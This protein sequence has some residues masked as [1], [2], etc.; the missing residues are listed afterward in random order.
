MSNLFQE[1][2]KGLNL[3]QKEAVDTIEGPVMVIAGPGTG[4]TQILTLRIARIL[5]ETD[6]SGDGILCL[7]FT[8][9]GVKA[10]RERLHKYIGED[11]RS[12]GIQ[13][14]HSF[15]N[16]LV[17]KYYELLEFEMP[18]KL[19][20]EEDAVLVVD[21]L[22]HARD[23]KHLHSRGNPALYF[24]DLKNLVSLLKRER[25]SHFDFMVEI[26]RDI[27]RLKNDPD[28][29]STRG[30]SKGNLKKEIQKKI[31]S[32]SR[33][34]EV[35]IF[36]ELYESYK[37]EN[38]LV[39]YDDVLE[40]AVKLV[41]ENDGVCADL[42]EAYLYV[43]VDEHQDS[44][45][46]QNAFLQAVWKST[47]KPN[48]FVVGDDRQ[49][50]Y[51][52]GGAS[53]SYFEEFKTAFGKA[54]LITLT[55]NYRSTAPILSLA[56][57]LLKS[58]LTHEKLNSNRE[59]TH[60]VSLFEYVYP[61]D[62]IIGAGLY[63]KQQI[64]NGIAP[65][66]CALLVPKNRH[67]LSALS[68]LQNLGIPVRS[69]H[70]VSFF[71]AHETQSFRNVL[72]V[73]VNPF[74]T[75]ALSQTILDRTSNIPIL[76][77]HTFLHE[78]D[79]RK[80]SVDTLV[81]HGKS[82]S[83]FDDA[84][85][86]SKWGKTL[87]LWITYSHTHSLI[88]II[89]KIGNELLVEKAVG[90]EELVLRVEIVR[91]SIHLATE[92]SEK[93]K[94][95]TLA[96]FLN[97]L[98]RLEQ[99]NHS[100]SMA[101]LGGDKGVSVMT[102]HGSKGLE[103]EHVWIG[104]M[105]ESVLMASKKAMFVL[106]ESLQ[107]KVE[108]KDKAVAKREL[109]VAIT[110][111]KKH[112]IISHATTSHTGGTLELAEI[113]QEIPQDIFDKKDATHTQ[114][115]LL[116][117][118]PRVYVSMEEKPESDALVILKENVSEIYT[119]AKV[120]VTLLNN[121]FE[122]PWKWYFRNLLKLPDLKTESLKF[123]SAVHSTIEKIL[124]EDKKPTSAFIKKTISEELEYEGVTDTSA[125]TRLTREGMEAVE[126][127]MEKYY[128]HLAKDRTTERS[129]SY[130]DSRFPDLTMYGKIDLTERFPDGRLVVTD[131]K[132]GTSKT[133]GMIEKRDDEGRL[134]SFM[135]QLAMY[136]YLVYGAEKGKVVDSSRLLFLEADL[137][138]KN[139]VYSTHVGNEE[140]DLLV[141]DI[142]DYVRLL[143]SGEWVDRPCNFKPL[144]SGASVCEHCELAK[145]VYG[146]VSS[147]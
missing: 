5:Q 60:P 122:C 58:S 105:N 101:T 30:E 80:L 59:E 78:T 127:W 79:T 147:K 54:H 28:S 86:I 34:K 56:D 16:T 134:S 65:E 87:S 37:K 40:Y 14:F 11:A 15:A 52:F 13:T 72:S 50:I 81:G 135:R 144:G 46:V 96:D 22:L 18:P 89:H 117:D 31:E 82:G 10:M 53:L 146:A 71:D 85:T 84:N 3:R 133:S 131:F 109:Y 21:Q 92:F 2:Y 142:S 43:L 26:D 76:D 90:H 32:L 57:T 27:D 4:K 107:A 6:T 48:I 42:R 77:A 62:E 74:D 132:T 108:Q 49:L 12:V 102:L 73:M 129:L 36:Y 120:S 29:I 124:L 63:F 19:L 39:D 123:G 83:L 24:N 44:S 64:E 69:T 100:L 25:L 55:E 9:A 94:K 68:T 17:E 98:N 20:K 97:Y 136:S 33:T 99:Y 1:A 61:R 145:R 118:D 121:F 114:N 51:G 104:H 119:D 116:A 66:E 140:I 139:G 112:C 35:A 141:R 106:P 38:D 125:L 8:R 7:T 67:V 75:I 93:N 138:D 88:E 110:R 41:E 45:G 47:E 126:V 115:E 111:A 143:S 23:W 113:L 128:P 137:D 91:T 130:R 103:F 70:G 95:A